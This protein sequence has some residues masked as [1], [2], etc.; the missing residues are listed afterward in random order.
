MGALPQLAS[1]D[2][3]ST[4]TIASADQ[5]RSAEC[6]SRT[7][8]TP[9]TKLISP[10]SR[11]PDPFEA[12]V[13]KA[14]GVSREQ[15]AS[16]VPGG[17]ADLLFEAFRGRGALNTCDANAAPS[18]ALLPARPAVEDREATYSEVAYPDRE[19][20]LRFEGA[21]LIVPPG[22]VAHEERLTMRTVADREAGALDTG[23]ANV[24]P[25]QRAFRLGPHGLR[26]LR[27]VTLI[28]P[29]NRT[30]MPAGM[31]AQDLGT[32]FFDAESGSWRPIRVRE[33]REAE[34]L[35]VAETEH[36]TD[37]INATLAVPDHP[38]TAS[39]ET[40]TIAD[41]KL[42]DPATGLEP[43]TTP[44]GGSDGAAHVSYKFTLPPGRRGLGPD[45]QL[46]YSSDA[47]N[48]WMG[49][50]WDIGL[51][52]VRIDSRF[53]VPR[54]DSSLETELYALDGSELT[55][56][57]AT[58]GPRE[59]QLHPA[60]REA[61]REFV[62]R[63]EGSFA[64]I[65]RHGSTPTAGPNA[66]WWELT[67]KNGTRFRYGVDAASRLSDSDT[68]RIAEWGLSE[69][70]DTY[71]NRVHY[72]YLLD[73][74][75]LGAGGQKW[76]QMYPKEIRYTDHGS[77]AGAMYVQFVLGAAGQRPDVSS[78]GRSGFLVRTARRLE[79][80][81]VFYSPGKRPPAPET[82]AAIGPLL[83]RYAFTYKTGEF[84][85]SLLEAIE[86]QAPDMN[87]ELQFRW[88]R[89]HK[90]AFTYF[91]RNP[92]IQPGFSGALPWGTASDKDVLNASSGE[93][94]GTNG[95]LGLGICGAFHAGVGGG[96]TGGNDR[97]SRTFLDFNG[98][99]LP[100][101]LSGGRALWGGASEV[102]GYRA[103]SISGLEDTFWETEQSTRS[104]NV[105]VHVAG[106]R[107]EAGGNWAWTNSKQQGGFADVDG[108]GFV[109]WVSPFLGL[110]YRNDGRGG[111]A[112]LGRTLTGRSSVVPDAL[113]RS[114]EESAPY[115]DPLVRWVAPYTG[116]VALSGAITRKTAGGGDVVAEIWRDGDGSPLWSRAFGST[117]ATACSPGGTTGSCDGGLTLTVNAGQAV[118][119]RTQAL[120]DM[121]GTEMLWDPLLSYQSVCQAGFCTAVSP[122]AHSELEPWGA[123]V[124]DFS[125][126]RDFR[127]AGPPN[128]AWTTAPLGTVN[129][130]V[131][132][133][134]FQKIA[135][136]A[137]DVTVR[138]VRVDS[139]TGAETELYART[140]AAAA[141]TRVDVGSAVPTSIAMTA[142]AALDA[143]G[144]PADF[145]ADLLR[146]EVV[147]DSPID[148]SA[149]AWSPE[150]WYQE[151]CRTPPTENASPVCG[152]LHCPEDGSDTCTM[153]GDPT[154]ERPLPRRLL[155]Q[156]APVTY[157]TYVVR[158][159]PDGAALSEN[160][161]TRAWAAPETSTFEATVSYALAASSAAAGA[162]DAVLLIQG[163]QR[164]LGKIRVPAGASGVQVLT[165]L[166]MTAGEP[167]YLTA[168]R[169]G[170]QEM[171]W[172][173]AL[174]SESSGI[175]YPTP[176][177]NSH[178]VAA[179]N[180]LNERGVMSG[181]YHQWS[182]GQ[183]THKTAS[184]PALS[185]A[186]I[187]DR[188][189]YE[190][191]QGAED[192]PFRPALVSPRGIAPNPGQLVAGSPLPA[193]ISSGLDLYIAAGELKPS[194][195]GANP[196]ALVRAAQAPAFRKS[197]GS[198][199]AINLSATVVDFSNTGSTSE[200]DV[201]LIDLNGDGYPDSFDT[202]SVQYGD[203]QGSF[204]PDQPRD[205]GGGFRKF[206]G[207]NRRYGLKPGS[208]AAGISER[209][210]ASGTVQSIL[211]AVP[212]F[213]RTYGRTRTTLDL[214]DINGDGLPDR[215]E[216]ENLGADAQVRLNLGYSFGPPFALPM[217]RFGSTIGD[218]GLGDT[219]S[220]AN[221]EAAL[222]LQ[223]N[224][225]NSYQIGY[226]GVGGGLAY[227]STR[228]LIDFADVTG[229]GL[230]DRVLKMPG[231][232][233]LYVQINTG[234]GFAPEQVWRMPDWGAELPSNGHFL[235]LGSRDVLAFSEGTEY[236]LG[237]G[238]AAEIPL[239]WALCLAVEASEQFVHNTLDAEL[240]FQD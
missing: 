2:P 210:G 184:S 90:T 187:E 206:E 183:W 63:A 194:R 125:Q 142:S 180:D 198:S 20:T 229:D 91:E 96:L 68:G 169:K 163:N 66:Y 41:L 235:G 84:S 188:R 185:N 149:V 236:H 114:I 32:F 144:A 11:T 22:A 134:V 112:P 7:K 157:S 62:R 9:L 136:T 162:D 240:V 231:R 89:R 209:L 71:G 195:V 101:F 26:F 79:A 139:L 213:G 140:F 73:S 61:E 170:N 49:L 86:L 104:L 239:F 33:V 224:V 16:R 191:K 135:P 46:S 47:G 179:W 158:G 10:V 133:G 161:P 43:M 181:G 155:Q 126:A 227:T 146:F 156:P 78:S 228:T 97:T 3:Q 217:A 199:S 223:T 109:D 164:L 103:A 137:D 177:L 29:F 98:D 147:S 76:V 143:S 232:S 196:L 219:T 119:F 34:G 44:T 182:T 138:V 105:G 121:A 58:S 211:N 15:S 99:G 176:V 221:E 82:S 152:A 37:F 106:D 237:I 165:G 234:E 93:Q 1:L 150:V 30:L 120:G 95:F 203:G 225:A 130:S 145:K 8:A 141:T 154:P 212:S 151:Y 178:R 14:L 70:E 53:G 54:Y 80:M 215:V 52:R 160:L 220:K 92:S 100:D 94:G 60:P 45:L 108:D 64:R 167:I 222:Q 233:R 190:T 28:L 25:G 74:G 69:V 67:D 122:S 204:G 23:M 127:L 175:N 56:R 24:T 202:G 166:T 172:N 17:S 128:Q 51:S 39:H 85:K 174:R 159:A 153:D 118:F 129:V 148:P 65:V 87:G 113:R 5:S 81:D 55:P 4:K 189:Q 48:G 88:S 230:P 18:P 102:T 40:N 116:T 19:S 110:I 115:A 131:Q 107:G 117:D 216:R 13:S 186:V 205:F 27:P 200:A 38:T 57:G 59:R 201:D 42:G 173:V 168:L 214:I 75:T 132:N 50:G 77:E 238:G 207:S 218:E 193:W 36:F 123:P 31:T 171:F 12:L 6:E 124:Y 226:G 208:G 21:T 35:V 197:H 72:E 192:L 83:R 111:L